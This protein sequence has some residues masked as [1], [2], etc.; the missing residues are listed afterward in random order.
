MR[1]YADSRPS[2][3]NTVDVFDRIRRLIDRA[4]ARFEDFVLAHD[5]EMRDS[6]AEADAELAAGKTMS[7]DELFETLDEPRE[8]HVAH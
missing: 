6:L 8:R 4:E 7:L 3:G 5:R 2:K 1:R